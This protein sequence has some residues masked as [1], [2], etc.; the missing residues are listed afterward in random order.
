MA[1]NTLETAKPKAYGRRVKDIPQEY[2]IPE[3]DYNK[4]ANDVIYVDAGGKPIEGNPRETHDVSNVT[5]YIPQTKSAIY[6]NNEQ[7]IS[8]SEQKRVERISKEEEVNKNIKDKT[9]TL[10]DFTPVL[11]DALQAK[12]VY[13]ALRSSNRQEA[14]ILL[15]SLLVPN[16]IEKPLK[17]VFKAGKAAYKSIKRNPDKVIHTITEDFI[18]KN[19]RK[20]T[21]K[22]IKDNR[23]IPF[24]SFDEKRN[25]INSLRD[26]YENIIIPAGQTRY[27]TNKLAI[28]EDFKVKPSNKLPVGNI[29]F[30]SH[31]RGV[32][33]F[34]YNEK[35]EGMMNPRDY[36]ISLALN[37]SKRPTIIMG[38][39]HI[40][41]NGA[42]EI[43]HIGQY[44]LGN[45]LVLDFTDSYKKRLGINSG[46]RNPIADADKAVL[47][48]GTI[49]Y[50]WGIPNEN[51]KRNKRYDND[52]NGNTI[53]TEI[54][55]N[56]L[57]K[58]NIN[59]TW[60]SS[61]NEVASDV[62]RYIDTKT[63]ENRGKV[64]IELNNEDKD[65]ITELIAKRFN[66]STK[67][68]REM[69]SVGSP[70]YFKNGGRITLED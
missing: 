44:E 56:P 42:H 69:L 22:A 57:A 14:G 7:Q 19:N 9:R 51:L 26:D 3:I 60:E 65:R 30:I 68:A 32:K 50:Y 43:N 45:D 66:L 21:L 61:P 40:L 11:G 4:H 58:N 46:S 25:Y 70:R 29:R 12:D 37:S 67:D 10:A 24:M 34:G 63:K 20:R 8:K 48:D 54:Q 41:G 39:N 17:T 36:S 18:N 52:L 1:K 35:T 47:Q 16:V 53:E 33:S 28:T 31:R 38:R 6:D 15:A 27:D 62:A 13:N 59:H 49:D 5:W 23:Y 55:F 64:F 2:R